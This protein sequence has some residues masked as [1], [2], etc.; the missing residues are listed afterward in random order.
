M[1]FFNPIRLLCKSKEKE[2][3]QNYCKPNVLRSKMRFESHPEFSLAL[4]PH[5][6]RVSG[7]KCEEDACWAK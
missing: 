2:T 6:R 3:I 5:D 4:S 1:P 7:W